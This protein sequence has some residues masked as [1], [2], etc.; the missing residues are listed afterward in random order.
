VITAVDTNVLIDIFIADRTFGE[1]S[2]QALRECLRQ[3]SVIACEVVWAEVQ[4]QF[5]SA[6]ESRLAM[7]KLQVRF[8]PCSLACAQSTGLAFARYRSKGGPKAR[9]LADFL[10][11]AHAEAEANQ[12]LTRDRGF[13]RTYFRDLAIID[14]A[15]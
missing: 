15:A 13:Y 9:V 5:P 11:G 3:G 6:S 12:L 7:E 10:V 1:Q 14:P 4:S 8:S 2:V